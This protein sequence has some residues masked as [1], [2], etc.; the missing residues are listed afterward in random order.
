MT[1][2]STSHKGCSAKFTWNV[3]TGAVAYQYDAVEVG[4]EGQSPRNPQQ[5]PHG[6]ENE[7]TFYGLW[8]STEYDFRVKARGNGSNIWRGDRLDVIYTTTFSGWATKRATTGQYN[9]PTPTPTPTPDVELTLTATPE[10]GRIRLTWTEVDIE[11]ISYEVKQTWGE[12]SHA[13][14]YVTATAPYNDR[15]KDLFTIS[16]FSTANGE[17]TALVDGWLDEGKSYTY[18]VNVK[19]GDSVLGSSNSASVT[20]PMCSAVQENP[21]LKIPLC[22]ISGFTIPTGIDHA[23][24]PNRAV[25]IDGRMLISWSAV[26]ASPNTIQVELGI[27]EKW[28]ILPHSDH[29]VSYPPAA[30]DR[31]AIIHGLVTGNPYSFRVSIYTGSTLHQT[32]VMDA[33]MPASLPRLGFH[34]DHTIEYEIDEFSLPLS[35]RNLYI[36]TFSRSIASWQSAVDLANSTYSDGPTIRFCTGTGCDQCGPSGN[37][38]CNT[39]NSM[40]TFLL[41]P[42]HKAEGYTNDDCG[43]VTACAFVTTVGD[44][45]TDTDVVFEYPAWGYNEHSKVHTEYR[46]TDDPDLDGE[47][48]NQ[49]D[50]SLR[51]SYLLPVSMHEVGHAAGAADLYA[52]K[53]MGRYNHMIMGSLDHDSVQLADGIYIRDI[54]R[55]LQYGSKPH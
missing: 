4:V 26:S 41:R 22:D 46:W 55:S 33:R 29:T 52:P 25:M 36:L 20:L 44:Y 17:V 49:G 28:D 7:W 8:C 6:P 51:Y 11:D 23:K 45:V 2:S 13:L 40:A 14:P 16:S 42:G 18:V 21:A 1:D 30:S 54:H 15:S 9:P 31:A 48:V 19:K 50:P 10:N 38:N 37:G 47:E 34:R 27:G 5:P 3:P 32:Q 24:N 53:Y 39:D 35:E 43:I 12:K